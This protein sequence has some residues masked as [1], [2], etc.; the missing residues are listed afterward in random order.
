MKTKVFILLIVC[1]SV[2]AAQPFADL[3][4]A[5]LRNNVEDGLVDYKKLLGDET[6]DKYVELLATFNP[7]SLKTREE[8]LAFWLNAYN[9]FTLKVVKDNYPIECVSELHTGGRIIGHIL[10]TTVWD[11]EI[12]VLNGKKISL[13]EIEHEI[14][15]KEFK[16]PRIHFAL[17]C[18]AVSCPPMRNEAYKPDELNAQL[19]GQAKAFLRNYVRNYF[20]LNKRE[21]Y[22][23][24]IFDWYGE[25]FAEDE[26]SLLIYLSRYLPDKVSSD[27]KKNAGL[28]EIEYLPYDW[29]LNDV[30][31][32]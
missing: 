14:I 16:E 10:K 7:A 9:A 29:K 6:L 12:F 27:I 23:S 19:D 25:D 15:R 24:K 32:K 22:L 28:W 26:D 17:V 4:D 8:Q 30:A 2:S 1:A 20:D 21:A 3:F 11:K 13:N 5:T 31:N 18:A